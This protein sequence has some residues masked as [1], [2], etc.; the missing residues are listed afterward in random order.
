LSRAKADGTPSPPEILQWLA[1]QSSGAYL[2]GGCIRDRLLGRPLHDLDLAVPAGG[3]ALARRIADHFGGDFYPLDEAR[4]IGRALFRSGQDTRLVVDVSDFRGPDLPSDLAD[5]DFAI[6]ALAEDLAAPGHYIDLFHGLDDLQSRIIRP[7]GAGSIRSDPVRAL[8]AARLAAELGFSLAEETVDLIRLDGPALAGVSAERVRDELAR[9]LLDRHSARSLALLDEL[10][11]LA[12]IFPELEPLRDMEQP[13]PHSLPGLAHSLET[14]RALECLAAPLLPARPGSELS[15]P[16]QEHAPWPEALGPLAPR[17]MHYLEQRLG[18]QRPRLTALKLAALLHDSGK[19]PA[20]AMH[21]D[22]R[23]HFIGHER[24]SQALAGGAARRLRLTGLEIRL[25]ET[26]AQHHM[27]PLLL[28]SVAGSHRRDRGDDISAHAVYRFF[29]D[30]GDCGVGVLL[31][32]MADHLATYRPDS[33]PE[34]WRHLLGICLQMLGDYFGSYAKEA[35][36]PPLLN[37]D[38]ILRQLSLSPGPQIGILLDAVREAQAC[39]EVN[40]REEALDLVRRLLVQGVSDL[41]A[42]E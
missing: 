31:H 13:A 26:V 27:R 6:N 21:T 14:V 1:A 22:G 10:G 28:A 23:V 34:A 3:L 39:G 24:L 18:D 5:R 17:L 12:I 38:D 11:L 41:P 29:R 30:T 16:L 4:G 40:T 20:M 19:A 37:G 15:V 9:I 36:P 32:A 42:C 25:V 35:A 2:V 8:R 7:V 33:A